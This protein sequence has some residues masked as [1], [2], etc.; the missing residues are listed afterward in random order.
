[1]RNVKTSTKVF[2]ALWYGVTFLLRLTAVII[3]VSL[4]I[5]GFAG[6]KG[7]NGYRDCN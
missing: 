3:T 2:R 4:L 1:M 5:V 6:D 7:F